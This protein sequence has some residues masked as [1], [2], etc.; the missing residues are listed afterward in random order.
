[1]GEE[2]R[3][4]QQRKR[5]K[6][7]IIKDRTGRRRIEETKGGEISRVKTHQKHYCQNDKR[8]QL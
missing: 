1:M 5:G 4:Q 2:K 8:D 6:E 7:I 3:K